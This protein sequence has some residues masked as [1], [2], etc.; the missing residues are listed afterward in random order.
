MSVLLA[1]GL[2]LGSLACWL[3]V[4]DISRTTKQGKQALAF[5]PLYTH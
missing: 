5:N 4:L 2:A 1:S 3:A